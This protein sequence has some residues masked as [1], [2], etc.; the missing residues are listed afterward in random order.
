MR[1][2]DK[3]LEN[4]ISSKCQNC[5]SNLVY[6]PQQNCLTCKYC[7]TN[8]F[9]PKK[10]EDA[11]LVR[12]YSSD[13]HP[14]EFN[15]YL[16]AYK[17]DNCGNVYYM[18]DEGTSKKC[19][20]CGSSSCSLT[21][22][23]GLCADGIIPFRISK[24]Q[25]AENFRK[26]LKTKKGVP[27]ALK[28]L[29]ENQKLMGVYIPVWNFSLN[30][31]GVYSASASEIKKDSSGSYF[32]YSKPVFGE[33]YKRIKSLDQ[34]ASSVEDEIFLDL[35]DENDYAGIIPYTPEYTY[36]YRVDA[37][38]K[39]IHDYYHKIKDDAEYDLKKTMKRTVLNKYKEVSDIS[40]ETRAEDVFFNFTYVPVYVNTYE[41]KNK[42]YKTY[43]SGTT[44]KVLGKSPVSAAKIFGTI[45]KFLGVG[46]VIALIAYLF[47]K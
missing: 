46:A 2:K 6:N 14:N 11:V 4:L 44:G 17:C 34:S 18:T 47:L 28:K 40:V 19:P 23:A 33:K 15:R 22:N 30:I 27:K 10:N 21:E 35:F 7:E 26:Y 5:G 29:A 41:H 39:S 8:Y 42:I 3:R 43:I 38:D 32:S 31:Y 16:Q 25:A 12:Q 45:L 37:I 9:L 1:L 13:F 24:K 36:G 20:N